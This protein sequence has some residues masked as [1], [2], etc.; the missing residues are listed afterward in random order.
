MIML[1][2][3]LNKCSKVETCN[4][5]SSRRSQE[6]NMER[7]LKKHWKLNTAINSSMGLA[8]AG[9]LV[10]SNQISLSESQSEHGMLLD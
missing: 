5:E 6:D 1:K 2:I 4:Q 9:F 8:E 7:E 3:E 10:Q